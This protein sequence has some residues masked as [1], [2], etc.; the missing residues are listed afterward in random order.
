VS[1]LSIAE[2]IFETINLFEAGKS[3]AFLVNSSIEINSP[4]F[5]GVPRELI[6]K[7]N[8]VGYKLLS[9]DVSDVEREQLG[10]PNRSAENIHLVK[11]ALHAITAIA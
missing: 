6:D 10:W 7:L 9:E 11:E 2:R 5:E 4:A 1:N 8:E 3:S